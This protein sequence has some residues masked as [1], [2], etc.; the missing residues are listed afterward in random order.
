[1]EMI[2]FIDEVAYLPKDGKGILLPVNKIAN[3]TAKACIQH[4]KAKLSDF[5]TGGVPATVTF[6][7]T[8][9]AKGNPDLNIRIHDCEDEGLMKR[10][11]QAIRS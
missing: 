10:I 4:F 8:V 6:V 2:T 9:V 11:E 1:M 3:E 5:D 7:G